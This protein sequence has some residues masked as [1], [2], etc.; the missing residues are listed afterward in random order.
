MLP[1]QIYIAKTKNLS[2][3]IER[4]NNGTGAEGTRD[5]RNHPWDIGAYTCGL[6]HAT[7]IECMSLEQKWK[8][9]VQNMRQW[10]IH[11]SYALMQAGHRIIKFHNEGTSSAAGRISFVSHVKPSA[12]KHLTEN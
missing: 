9:A 2:H 3:C 4:H 7:K 5:P 1:K 8:M 6:L 11:E 10:G 12:A